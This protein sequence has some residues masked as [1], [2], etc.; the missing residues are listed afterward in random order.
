MAENNEYTVKVTGPGTNFEGLVS[1][2]VGQ[3]II[4]AAV[5][6]A[7]TPQVA[8]DKIKAS[9]SGQSAP[10]FVK[11]SEPETQEQQEEVT[12]PKEGRPSKS[13]REFF[14]EVEPSRN[15]DRIATIGRY[16]E[17]FIGN[18]TFTRDD[19]TKWFMQARAAV[20]KNLARDINWAIRNGWIAEDPRQEGTYY[21]T[22][23]GVSVVDKKFPDEA[24]EKT[25]LPSKRRRSSSNVEA[26]GS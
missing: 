16:L 3:Q 24:L 19:L 13:I 9:P 25:R 18:D 7:Y 14:N 11:Q 4:I 26:N 6:G 2:E 10:A 23:A 17:R 21:L 20:P 1:L 22:E 15:P 12:T 5:T 8:P